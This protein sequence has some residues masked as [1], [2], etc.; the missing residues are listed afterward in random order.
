M[1][2]ASAHN[3][4]EWLL[5][6]FLQHLVVLLHSIQEGRHYFIWYTVLLCGLLYYLRD[7]RIVNVRYVREKMVLYLIVKATHKP[8]YP[9]A[10][11][12][13]IGS[14]QHLVYC[15]VILHFTIF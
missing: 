8:E 9:V 10:A 6:H 7:L 2:M 11:W 4:I 14:V 3:I 13:K 5:S 12:R 1:L 15:P